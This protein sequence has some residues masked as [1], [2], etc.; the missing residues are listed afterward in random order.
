MMQFSPTNSVNANKQTIGELI[1]HYVNTESLT[2]L[3]ATSKWL[4]ENGIPESGYSKYI[5]QIIIDKIKKESQE[6]NL[7][8]PSMSDKESNGLD[9]IYG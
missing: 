8:R 5:P 7:L 1:E 2:Y 9:F 3:E 4:D 6:D